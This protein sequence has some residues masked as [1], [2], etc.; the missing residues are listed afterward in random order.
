MPTQLTH[1]GII[2][3]KCRCIVHERFTASDIAEMREAYPGAEIL[4]HPECPED[5]LSA[6]AVVSNRIGGLRV[7][8]SMSVVCVMRIG[9]AAFQLTDGVFRHVHVP[10]GTARVAPLRS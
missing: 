9:V 6:A 4:A 1:I 5:V 2:A 3:W 7:M 8:R 10:G